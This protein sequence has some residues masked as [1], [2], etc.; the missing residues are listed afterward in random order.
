MRCRVWRGWCIGR[1]MRRFFICYLQWSRSFSRLLCARI[2]TDFIH[3]EF[4]FPTWLFF[5]NRLPAL[6]TLELPIH[7]YMEGYPTFL[8]CHGRKLTSLTMA[9]QSHVPN[10]LATL[11][12]NV[13]EL[14]IP[15]TGCSMSVSRSLLLPNSPTMSLTF[16]CIIFAPYSSWC[17]VLIRRAANR[18][19]TRC[20]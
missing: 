2:S 17:T 15:V 8:G 13:K 12:P 3:F 10:L 14:V 18:F 9:F 7:G 20:I 19:S 5:R 16:H 1:R 6:R 11:C 4:S